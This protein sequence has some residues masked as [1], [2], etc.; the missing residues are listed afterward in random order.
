MKKTLKLGEYFMK[1]PFR[2]AFLCLLKREPLQDGIMPEWFT[3]L[4]NWTLSD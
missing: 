3:K 4:I 1:K 2:K